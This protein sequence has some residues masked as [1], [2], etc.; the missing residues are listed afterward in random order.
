M[1]GVGA[2]DEGRT[3]CSRRLRVWSPHTQPKQRRGQQSFLESKEEI[4]K[5][6]HS[7]SQRRRHI[8]STHSHTKSSGSRC[9]T[10]RRHESSP[11]GL[12]QVRTDL[13]GRTA[14]QF[15]TPPK[16]P[17]T[18]GTAL[19]PPITRI[20]E[21]KFAHVRQPGP[22]PCISLVSCLASILIRCSPELPD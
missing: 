12:L 3:A 11:D 17:T 1:D 13:L 14:W 19:S 4:M 20:A 15:T 9:V 22:I 16:P 10:M 6:R 21:L 5:R 18:L 7:V 2:T 8:K